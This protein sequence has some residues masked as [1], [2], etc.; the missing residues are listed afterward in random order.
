MTRVGTHW[1]ALQVTLRQG[2]PRR[3]TQPEYSHLWRTALKCLRHRRCRSTPLWG[4]VS[5]SGDKPSWRLRCRC[6]RVRECCQNTSVGT[7]KVSLGNYLKMAS[8]G[9]APPWSLMTTNRYSGF[10]VIQLLI[11][12]MSSLNWL[13]ISTVC[14]SYLLWEWQRLDSYQ[15]SKKGN[16]HLLE[17]FVIKFVDDLCGD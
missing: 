8:S 2:R 5:G 15:R 13:I 11:I 14:V 10:S 7:V 9:H 12:F 16:S 3:S 1:R 17:S 6:L 4:T